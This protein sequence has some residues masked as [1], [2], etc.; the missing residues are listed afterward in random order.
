MGS[1]A[2]L[3][4]EKVAQYSGLTPA[5][6]DLHTRKHGRSPL[7]LL[8][9]NTSLPPLKHLGRQQPNVVCDAGKFPPKLAVMTEILVPQDLVSHEECRDRNPHL[10]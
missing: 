3:R 2:P 6:E 4:E 9:P 1:S 5:R 7:F 10:A 8:L